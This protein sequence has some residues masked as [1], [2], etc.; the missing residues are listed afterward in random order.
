MRCCVLLLIL[1]SL[2]FSKATIS[3]HDTVSKTPLRLQNIA[4]IAA[5]KRL[6][7]FVATIE[8]PSS[9]AADGVIEP[10]EVRA[11]LKKE[12]ID[13][14]RFAIVGRSFI[15]FP[16]RTLYRSDIEQMVRSRF[17]SPKYTIKHISFSLAKIDFH[18]PFRLLYTLQSQT[19]S[20]IYARI[21]FYEG[22]TLKKS[23][24]VTLLIEPVVKFAVAKHDIPKGKLITTE[25][26]EWIQKNSYRGSIDPVGKVATTTI[27]RG[28]I[29]KEYMLEPRYA[30]KKRQNVTI[31]YRKGAI[32]IKLLGLALQ[33][34]M[35]GD[36]IKVKNIGSGKVLL[37]EVVSPSVVRYVH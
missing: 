11:L 29:I 35:V 25:D 18:K 4:S 37:C 13:T 31:L 22:K 14:S 1:S 5:S 7:D 19:K 27:R 23:L 8:I 6:R 34:G 21:S 2:L 3:L 17:A 26:I 30:V 36:I 16:P 10:K 24:P 12:G 15:L 28:R 33:N 9:Y 20:H 32:K